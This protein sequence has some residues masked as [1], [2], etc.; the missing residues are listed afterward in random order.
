M[1]RARCSTIV[2]IALIG[3]LSLAAAGCSSPVEGKYSN[4]VMAVEFKSGKA[5]VT[6]GFLTTEGTY[7][8]EGDK[9]IIDAEGEK[10]IL[11]RN[12]DGSLSGPKESFIGR[13]TK[14]RS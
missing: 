3:C 4:G 14:Q 12:P 2:I 1:I 13:L 7:Q 9:I 10:L 11:T 5:Y 6:M 8:V